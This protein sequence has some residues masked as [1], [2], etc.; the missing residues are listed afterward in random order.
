MAH[1]T[2]SLVDALAANGVAPA[3]ITLVFN[4]HSHIDHSH[5]NTLFPRARICC[6]HRDR[7]W[8]RAVH[9][10]LETTS[11]PRAEDV[12]AFYPELAA[13]SYDAKT[14]AKIL[15]IEKLLWDRTRLG[16]DEQ[17]SW[18]EDCPPPPGITVVDTPG[19]TPYHV[20]FAIETTGR[21]VLVCGDALL[22]RDEEVYAAPM[23]AP[24]SS[25]LYRQS[26]HLI[27]SFD[28]IVVPGHDAPF[29]NGDAARHG[30]NQNSTSNP[31]ER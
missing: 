17:C 20:S 13:D 15:G 5:N 6:S 1:H 23:M 30:A 22:L 4:T 8:T 31:P 26:Q 27:A 28:G 29:E 9:A 25:A 14:V 12:V 10:V 19:H 21:R 3:E 18:L 2:A 7:A 11:H 16:P 24:W